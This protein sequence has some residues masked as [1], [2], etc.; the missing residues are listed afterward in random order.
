[1]N[2]AGPP[3]PIANSFE[4]IKSRLQQKS[5]VIGTGYGVTS[6][7]S[8]SQIVSIEGGLL[9]TPFALPRFISLRMRFERSNKS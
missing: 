9:L 5:G 4:T 2:T 8:G 3:I 1:M 6:Q 7:A